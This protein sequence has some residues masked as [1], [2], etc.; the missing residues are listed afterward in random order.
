[1]N[2]DDSGIPDGGSITHSKLNMERFM[3]SAD[4]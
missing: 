4:T 2:F 3:V 1:M